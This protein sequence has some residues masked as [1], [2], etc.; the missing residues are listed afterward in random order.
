VTAPTSRSYG[1]LCA[2]AAALDVVG[3]R[4]ALLVVRDLLFGPMRFVDLADALPGV[5]TNT[6]TARLKQLESAGIVE[7]AL[8][9]RPDRSTVY[10]L[11]AYGR[12][13]EPILLALGRWGVRSMGLLP[14]E[15]VERSR[16]LLAAVLAFHDPDRR[17]A[18]P[19]CWELRLGEGPFTVRADGDELT[20]QAGAPERPDHTLS[21]SERDLVALLAG[22]VA[23]ASAIANG[24][25]LVSDPDAL[26]SLLALID[27]PALPAPEFR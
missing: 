14:P 3:E 1:Q 24:S 12:E 6:L 25:C 13:L 22:W 18:G 27:F 4:W 5:G 26:P 19:T 15:P 20:I 11:T 9:P 2:V 17:P 10:R 23:P 16:P 8:R 7:R 21:V